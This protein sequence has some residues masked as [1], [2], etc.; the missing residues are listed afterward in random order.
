[1]KIGDRVKT[2]P[3]F[4]KEFAEE[5]VGVITNISTGRA[6][7]DNGEYHPTKICTAATIKTD[8]GFNRIDMHWLMVAENA[9]ENE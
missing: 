5:F 8:T 2:T 6:R 4:A 9:S 1:M 7:M 3:L